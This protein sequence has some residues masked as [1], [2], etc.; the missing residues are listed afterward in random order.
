M[1]NQDN[2]NA[3]EEGIKLQNNTLSK[4]ENK[5]NELLSEQERLNEGIKKLYMDKY[6]GSITEDIFYSLR[7]NF[8]KKIKNN[9]SEIEFIENKIGFIKNNEEKEDKYKK[10]IEKCTNFEKLTTEM[11][12]DFIDYVEVCEKD[13]NKN[14][15]VIIHWKF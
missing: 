12:F 13:K 14:Q 6:I 10:I 1:S 5:R 15:K 3:V 11:V 4:E 9:K 7:D 8:E 2:F